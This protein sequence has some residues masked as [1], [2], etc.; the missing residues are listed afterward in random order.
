MS[1]V[2]KS[3][4][5]SE[6]QVAIAF[7]IAEKKYFPMTRLLATGNAQ[8]DLSQLSA[9]RKAMAVFGAILDVI[10]SVIGIVYA[11]ATYFQNREIKAHNARLPD[12]QVVPALENQLGQVVKAALAYKNS[13]D[14]HEKKQALML[15]IQKMGESL[16]MAKFAFPDE[17]EEFEELVR[18]RID[19]ELGNVTISLKPHQNDDTGRFDY[20]LSELVLNG[21]YRYIDGAENP[22]MNG[23][24]PEFI[25]YRFEEGIFV[26]SKERVTN[27][28]YEQAAID[29]VKAVKHLTANLNQI[30]REKPKQ[31]KA[32]REAVL[33]PII[34]KMRDPNSLEFRTIILGSLGS[35]NP[36]ALE[37]LKNMS[38]EEIEKFCNKLVGMGVIPESQTAS[39]LKGIN[40]YK[41]LQG[42]GLSPFVRG[43]KTVGALTVAGAAAT[44]M[45][46][47]PV[48]GPY[49]ASSL[50][51]VG[52]V[53]AKGYNLLPPAVTGPLGSAANY[54]GSALAPYAPYA[55]YVA[56]ILGPYA[57]Y[58]AY[59]YATAN[60]MTPAQKAAKTY[61]AAAQT[62]DDALAT[63]RTAGKKVEGIL[64]PKEI[65]QKVGEISVAVQEADQAMNKAAK[66][67]K[68]AGK[69]PA[70]LPE[71][72][73]AVAV[74]KEKADAVK[75]L[76]DGFAAQAEDAV[77][78][79]DL[80]KLSKR[81]NK[82]LQ[83][84]DKDLN[85]LENDFLDLE[86]KTV[87]ELSV[88]LNY[89]LKVR[90]KCA[91]ALPEKAQVIELY[92][93]EISALINE[94]KSDPTKVEE[95]RTKITKSEQHYQLVAQQ[96]EK[97]K[98][99]IDQIERRIAELQ[100]NPEQIRDF[101]LRS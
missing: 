29:P 15:Q 40:N 33:K 66:K 71:A 13:P 77:K 59:Q 80:S 28:F 97:V 18:N 101:V 14:S 65:S 82:D 73:R 68:A 11:A 1:S 61:N 8:G 72:E 63:V 74:A 20:P 70:K 12:E 35:A 42:A 87:Y 83:G 24:E 75:R 76:A 37:R 34:E 5:G 49:V 58:K 60:D 96:F 3:S 9:A 52:G 99:Q 21:F 19:Q 51:K 88:T 69:D 53:L 100:K 46:H 39:V 45:T 6:R 81:L 22:N 93:A 56:A 67:I 38:D 30:H 91:K 57:L 84:V 43:A 16:D 79:K 32:A 55:P 90:D 26:P 95:L 10:S 50:G 85:S 7:P 23:V 36:K 27:L 48:V 98:Q 92:K 25:S 44:Q 2:E 86:G 94:N 89:K 31:T 4:I 41:R 17:S 62:M 54:V 78:Y 64:E 47:L